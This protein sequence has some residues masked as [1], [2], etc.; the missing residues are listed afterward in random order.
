MKLFSLLLLASSC[1]SADTIDVFDFENHM[2]NQFTSCTWTG[3]SA[4]CGG[5]LSVAHPDPA[6]SVAGFPELSPVI[7]VGCFV[8]SFNQCF[9]TDVHGLPGGG[10]YYRLDCPSLSRP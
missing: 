7:T 9:E 2:Q 8:Y 10:V 5:I 4:I 3:A 6:P 1:A